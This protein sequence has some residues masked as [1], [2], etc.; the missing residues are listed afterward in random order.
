MTKQF[1]NPN[2]GN[3]PVAYSRENEAQFRAELMRIIAG[4]GQ[5][6]DG[7]ATGLAA[8]SLDDDGYIVLAVSSSDADTYAAYYTLNNTG[9]EE[10]DAEDTEILASAMPYSDTTAIQLATGEVGYLWLKFYSSETGFGQ[11]VKLTIMNVVSAPKVLSASMWVTTDVSAKT[12]AVYAKVVAPDVGFFPA[13]ANVRVGSPLNETLMV[14][15]HSFTATNEKI[16]PTGAGVGYTEY[17]GL[18]AIALPEVGA[19]H[20][21]MDVTD[22]Y[23]NLQWFRTSADLDSAPDAVVTVVDYQ[24]QPKLIIDYDDDVAEI[25]VACPDSK[26]KSWTGLSGGGSVTY[27]V[28]VT[29]RDSDPAEAD[30]EIGE[31]RG[32]GGVSDDFYVVTVFGAA[33]ATGIYK[34]VY[35]GALHGGTGY[36]GI[37]PAIVIQSEGEVAFTGLDIPVTEDAYCSAGM[38]YASTDTWANMHGSTG[39]TYEFS[40]VSG[41]LMVSVYAHASTSGNWRGIQ[42]SIVTVP[43]DNIPTGTVLSAGTS[44]WLR[45]SSVAETFTAGTD[46]SI[47]LCGATPADPDLLVYGDYND[48]EFGVGYQ[49]LD[50]PIVLDDLATG[51]WVEF[52]LN[53]DALDDL[54]IAVDAHTPFSFGLAITAD[55]ANTEPAWE[56]GAYSKVEFYSSNHATAAYHPY[57]EVAGDLAAAEMVLLLTDPD[58]RA[59]EIETRT[60]LGLGLW[61]AWTNYV[62]DTPDL[63]QALPYAASWTYDNSAGLTSLAVTAKNE[64]TQVGTTSL[65]GRVYPNDRITLANMSTAGNNGLDL[66]ILSVTANTITVF[67]SPLTVQAADTA[68]TLTRQPWATT[69]VVMDSKHLSWIQARLKYLKETYPYY[70]LPVTSSGFDIGR[71]P[72]VTA[73]IELG[74][75]YVATVKKVTASVSVSG[76]WDTRS[77]AVLYTLDGTTPDDLGDILAREYLVGRT[78]TAEDVANFYEDMPAIVEE[79]QTVTFV[80]VAFGEV[81]GTGYMSAIR[82][83]K[84]KRDY[85]AGSELITDAT[86]IAVISDSPAKDTYTI[87]WTP[88]A[89]VTDAFQ[90][91]VEVYKRMISGNVVLVQTGVENS[92]D[93]YVSMVIE[94]T[95]A[96]EGTAYPTTCRAD[97]YLYNGSSVLVDSVTIY[98]DLA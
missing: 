79:G 30:M 35:R 68:C 96:W 42:R 62:D 90:I 36:E 47:M 4:M 37:D 29:A 1:A 55:F 20:F 34:V 84:W 31:T 86:L 91:Y 56:A 32:T 45:V 5:R 19:L 61:S 85:T 57:L 39:E 23:G 40:R 69:R 24:A 75:T 14:T 8:M 74:E 18:A 73:E 80:V 10:P 87:G 59:V 76:D 28:G 49:Y 12:C 95:E 44:L 92:P 52:V 27:Q 25:T 33:S 11:E 67:G 82:V 50:T 17:A 9:F 78:F 48:L 41:V 13:S 21:Y 89:S 81:D 70:T 43:M 16:G 7:Y 65:V 66:L 22:A 3:P 15:A 98:A 83:L 64:I 93:T 2:L 38:W 46:M 51:D 72:D 6:I 88:A 63:G 77:I 60:K 58:L 26:Y 97:I 53:G 94:D 71:V 54:Q